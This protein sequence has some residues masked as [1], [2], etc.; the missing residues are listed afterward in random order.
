MCGLCRHGTY[1]CCGAVAN[2]ISEEVA[3][4]IF[5][6]MLSF[7]SY[8]FNKSHAA[9]YAVVS[10]RTA[11]LKCHYP[12][13]YMAAL[14]TSVLGSQTK[15]AE[16]IGECRDMGIRLLSKLHQVPEEKVAKQLKSLVG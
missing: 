3:N 16:Y 10:Y 1:E 14:L 6:D 12:Q 15:V 8:A 11:Y 4:G 5:D 9:A 7:A 13:Q 2:G